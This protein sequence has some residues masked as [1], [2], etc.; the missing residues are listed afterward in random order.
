MIHLKIKTIEELKEILKEEDKKHQELNDKKDEDVKDKEREKEEELQSKIDA[1]LETDDKNQV[2]DTITEVQEENK[3]DEEKKDGM[4]FGPDVISKD[5]GEDKYILVSKLGLKL[6]PEDYEIEIEEDQGF[7]EVLENNLLSVEQVKSIP[8]QDIIACRIQHGECSPPC[9]GYSA[10]NI[11]V[12]QNAYDFYG[13]GKVCYRR[14][15]SEIKKGV[16][17][18][19]FVS[20]IQGLLNT[21]I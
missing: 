20:I 14:E 12:Q 9:Q 2:I 7:E 3:K 6:D 19:G 13:Y 1:A 21:N 5:A 16:L 17:T 15:Y 8:C 10:F 18:T 11:S 4:D